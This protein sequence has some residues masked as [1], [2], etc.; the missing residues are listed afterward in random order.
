MFQALMIL[1]HLLQVDINPFLK[2]F[3]EKKN[4]LGFFIVICLIAEKA[5]RQVFGHC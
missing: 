4:I 1:N 5:F 3:D 2:I